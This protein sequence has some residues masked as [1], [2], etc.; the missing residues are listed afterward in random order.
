M[1]REQSENG[2]TYPTKLLRHMILIEACLR[3]V[4]RKGSMIFLG[5][6][7]LSFFRPTIDVLKPLPPLYSYTTSRV[8]LYLISSFLQN[9]SNVLQNR[10]LPSESEPSAYVLNM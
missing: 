10:A 6:N 5:F 1:M 7:L 9:G 8:A 3:S 4:H 2:G